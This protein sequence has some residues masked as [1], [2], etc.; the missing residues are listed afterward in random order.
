MFFGE[1]SIS[2]RN[3]MTSERKYFMTLFLFVH[4][5][6]W[7]GHH[8]NR[9][10][11]IKMNFFVVTVVV[12]ILRGQVR[13]CGV[14]LLEVGLEGHLRGAAR[15]DSHLSFPTHP[16]SDSV[17]KLSEYYSQIQWRPMNLTVLPDGPCIGP[18]LKMRWD[19]FNHAELLSVLRKLKKQKAPGQDERPLEHF[20]TLIGNLS[21]RT[22][23]LLISWLERTKLFQKPGNVQR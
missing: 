8:L 12:V 5:Y 21:G 1:Y 3:W 2:Y 18:V 11:L 7:S 6:D 22:E 23:V 19:A 15:R 9:R 4:K 17:P 13:R 14:M 20:A 10:K 16:A